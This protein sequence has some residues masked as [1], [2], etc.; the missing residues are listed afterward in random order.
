MALVYDDLLEA[1]SEASLDDL[2]TVSG[3][4]DAEIQC[5]SLDE[6][7]HGVNLD[8]VDAFGLRQVDSDNLKIILL[9]SAALVVK[10]MVLT[11]DTLDLRSASGYDILLST[12][13]TQL[14]SELEAIINDVIR[15]GE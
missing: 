6:Q 4:V 2:E 1:K 10:D 9:R 8:W 11:D 5:G 14:S 13:T 15:T 3:A 12:I 7:L